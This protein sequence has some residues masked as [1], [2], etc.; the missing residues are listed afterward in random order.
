[1]VGGVISLSFEASD[2]QARYRGLVEKLERFDS[3]SKN[4][5]NISIARKTV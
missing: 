3:A 2:M 1:M 4:V 5:L